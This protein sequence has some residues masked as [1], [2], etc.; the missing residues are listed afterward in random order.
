M[1]SKRVWSKYIKICQFE[2]FARC[3]TCEGEKSP[4]HSAFQDLFKEEILIVLAILMASYT[5][6][7][8]LFTIS[9]VASPTI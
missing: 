9:S 2:K 6:K 8:I 3:A 5:E 1:A 7:S 4:F